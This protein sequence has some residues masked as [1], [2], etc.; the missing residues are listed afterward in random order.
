MTKW[1]TC[2]ITS[3][4]LCVT[5]DD[6]FLVI[7]EHSQETNIPPMQN[8]PRMPQAPVP[9]HAPHMAAG[10]AA[11][12]STPPLTRSESAGNVADHSQHTS[13]THVSTSEPS[14]GTADS[15]SVVEPASGS[16]VF[17]QSLPT[18]SDETLLERGSNSQLAYKVSVE[19][20]GY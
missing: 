18:E 13:S 6:L 2:C 7:E 19:K 16:H 10:G 8:V 5:Y 11:Q 14:N 1:D 9:V 4:V 20:K 15:T 3:I 17:H 12:P